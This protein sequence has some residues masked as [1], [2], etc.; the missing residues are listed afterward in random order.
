MGDYTVAVGQE[1]RRELAMALL[2]QGERCALSG[3][4]REAEAI[5]AQVWTIAEE[6]APD[7]ANAAAWELAWLL[8]R[9][10]AYTEATEWFCRV[11]VP[12]ARASLL[13][14]AAQ[15]GDCTDLPGPRYAPA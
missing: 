9:R 14:P 5:L 4:L 1:D 2:Q 6:P 12:L 15:Q 8:V 13:W 10:R 3:L 11:E 7:L